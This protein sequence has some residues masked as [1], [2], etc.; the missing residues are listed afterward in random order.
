MSGT[1]DRLGIRGGRF[2]P[3]SADAHAHYSYFLATTTRGPEAVREAET[4][5][6]LDPLDWTYRNF[7][8]MAPNAIGRKDDAIATFR[9]ILTDSSLGEE[10]EREIP[11]GNALFTALLTDR[12]AAEFAALQREMGDTSTDGPLL[13]AAKTDSAARRQVLTRLG[14]GEFRFGTLAA[15]LYMMFGMPDSAI[16][17][18]ERLLPRRDRNLPQIIGDTAF[19]PLA[20]N[21]RFQTILRALGAAP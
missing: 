8:G 4:A 18:L 7:L 19:F 10:I 14:R 5:V 20:P 21:P 16:T 6:Q 9:A 11:L 3:G 13:Q 1:P 12:S 17:E 2:E 15:L